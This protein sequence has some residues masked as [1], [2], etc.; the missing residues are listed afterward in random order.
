MRYVRRSKNFKLIPAISPFKRLL[1]LAVERLNNKRRNQGRRKRLKNK[2]LRPKSLKLKEIVNQKKSIEKDSRAVQV[3]KA[4][5]T[6]RRSTIKLRT[7]IASTLRRRNAKRDLG[8][9]LE[10]NLVVL[11]KS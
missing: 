1:L 5:K 4:I 9:G 8:V 7:S 6:R 10:C 2:W 3:K 11:Y